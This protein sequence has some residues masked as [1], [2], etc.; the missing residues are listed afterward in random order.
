MKHRHDVAWV[1]LFGREGPGDW[2]DRAPHVAPRTRLSPA[3]HRPVDLTDPSTSPTRRPHQ[4]RRPRAGRR[5]QP[6]RRGS[7]VVARTRRKI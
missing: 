5:T 1:R 4:P 7:H 6:R 3:P 2:T